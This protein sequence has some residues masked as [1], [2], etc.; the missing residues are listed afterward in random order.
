MPASDDLFSFTR[1]HASHA[2]TLRTQHFLFPVPQVARRGRSLRTLRPPS[3]RSCRRRLLS[4]AWGRVGL[5]VRLM[6]SCL[7][8][9]SGRPWETVRGKVRG[10]GRR[11]LGGR[12]GDLIS[13]LFGR[14][15]RGEGSVLLYP[16]DVWLPLMS[17]HL[18][19]NIYATPEI[20]PPLYIILWHNLI[21]QW[22][23]GWPL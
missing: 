3:P 18:V 13:G 15:L 10:G 20:R 22:G 6:Q 23:H 14:A 16:R 19:P 8:P 5:C 2:P 9:P 17:G 12:G 4:M 11:P 7:T 21:P 1:C